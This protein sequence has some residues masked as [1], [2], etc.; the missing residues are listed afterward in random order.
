MLQ[1]DEVEKALEHIK[2]THEK[3]GQLVAVLK[4]ATSST[5]KCAIPLRKSGGLFLRCA[6]NSPRYKCRRL[7]SSPWHLA[8]ISDKVARDMASN[9]N[10]VSSGST[11]PTR[12]AFLHPFQSKTLLTTP[13]ELRGIGPRSR[14]GL[15]P[16]T[17]RNNARRASS[18]RLR[19]TSRTSTRPSP[20]PAPRSSTRCRRRLRR[21]PAA[22]EIR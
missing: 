14:P 20:S 3:Y 22:P 1:I 10:E 9:E 8:G 19:R 21:R 6:G 16:L 11:R 5:A 2:E 7:R 13:S 18:R 4:D 12:Q 17:N 15:D